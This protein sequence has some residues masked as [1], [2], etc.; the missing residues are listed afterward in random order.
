MLTRLDPAELA[1]RQNDFDVQRVDFGESED[2]ILEGDGAELA[3]LQ[4][5]FDDHTSERAA[6]C[7]Q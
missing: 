7:P 5:H 4:Q 3:G 6:N 2:R 1:D